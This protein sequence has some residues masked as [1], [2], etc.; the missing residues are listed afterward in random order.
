MKRLLVVAVILI[1]IVFAAAQFVLPNFVSG[2][3]KSKVEEAFHPTQQNVLVESTPAIKLLAGKVDILKGDLNGVTLKNGLKFSNINVNIKDISF[4]PIALFSSTEF[5]L[6]SVGEGTLSGTISEEALSEFLNEKVKGLNESIVTI[7]SNTVRLTGKFSIGGILEGK[8]VAS[9]TIE[10]RGDKLLF[11]PRQFA[12]NGISI[13][14]LT[15]AVM[16]EVIIYDFANF[17]IPVHVQKVDT[18]KGKIQV[19][20]VPVGK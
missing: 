2:Q 17:P 20:L 16:N 14:G 8:A 11:A 12:I 9:G 4:D 10:L 1:A 7:D 18:E 15:S 19:V 3:L 5:R 6:T 13:N